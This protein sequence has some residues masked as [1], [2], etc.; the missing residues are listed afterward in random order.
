MV[1]ARHELSA[2]ARRRQELAHLVVPFAADAYSREATVAENL[3]FGT[4]VGPIFNDAQLATN[5]YL[6]AG[7]QGESASISRSSSMGL[8][9]AATR[10]SC[11]RI[12]RRSIRS[13]SSS[14]S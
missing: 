4:P 9:I 11:S 1:E 12:C 14:A 5:A 7:A 13:S 2:P 6:T 10:S 8:Q 3:L